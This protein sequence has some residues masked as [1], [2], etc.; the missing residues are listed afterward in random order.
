MAPLKRFLTINKEELDEGW[1]NILEI[2]CQ[3]MVYHLV[4][5]LNRPDCKKLLTDFVGQP[6]LITT[7]AFAKGF[8]ER[9]NDIIGD[10]ILSSTDGKKQSKRV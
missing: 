1:P 5:D 3:G 7:T 10:P 4:I 8:L 6:S 2:M 9:D